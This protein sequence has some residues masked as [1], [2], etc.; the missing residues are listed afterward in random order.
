M[1]TETE[2]PTIEDF[3]TVITQRQAEKA[4]TEDLP[5]DAEQFPKEVVRESA[6]QL[7]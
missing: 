5:L 1:R 2:K 7:K 3:A 6:F 4:E